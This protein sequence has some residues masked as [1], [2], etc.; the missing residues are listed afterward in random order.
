MTIGAHAYYYA[1]MRTDSKDYEVLAS[2]HLNN[3][4]LV[5]WFKRRLAV[6]EDTTRK[7]RDE[8]DV[9]WAQGRAQELIEII[10][11]LEG[12]TNILRKVDDRASSR[13]SA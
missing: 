4:K 13:K 6:T 9:R 7:G 1:R 3:P 2:A 12:A 5:E 10:E 11:A 8:V